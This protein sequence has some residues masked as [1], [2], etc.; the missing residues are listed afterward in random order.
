MA[1][2]R[3][4]YTPERPAL[5]WGRHLLPRRLRARIL[6]VALVALLPVGLLV[7]GRALARLVTIGETAR[8]DNQVAAQGGAR[9][10]A[11]YVEE[12]RQQ[13]V[14]LGA[15]IG[16]RQ[17]NWGW[18]NR[19]LATSATQNPAL[20]N[21]SW[22]SSQGLVL[23]SSAPAALGAVI[24]E[25]ASIR[26][27]RA[28][29]SWVISDLLP[30]GPISRSVSIVLASA[31]RTSGGDLLGILV[32]EVNPDG[33]REVLE[34]A[35][36]PAGSVAVLFDR[37]GTLVAGSDARQRTWEERAAWRPSDPVLRRALA[38][39]REAH[40]V[41]TPVTLATPHYAVYAPTA[42]T[43]YLVG[44]VQP[45]ATARASVW[46]SALRDV[47][48]LALVTGLVG[49]IAYYLSGTIVDPVRRLRANLARVERQVTGVPLS[50]EAPAE[51]R[52]LQAALTA[53]TATLLQRIAASEGDRD[54][55][56]TILELLPVGV[57]F[58]NA[59]GE[60][61]LANPSA[62]ELFGEDALGMAS[63][64]RGRYS[65]HRPDGSPLPLAEVPLVAALHEGQ[66][67]RN[68]EVIIRYESGA[69][70]LALV[71]ATPVPDPQGATMGVVE[72]VVEVV[73]DAVALQ[74]ISASTNLEGQLADVRA[75]LQALLEIVPVGVFLLDAGGGL[76][77][78]NP[79]GMRLWG[80][81]LPTLKT[82]SDF[83]FLHGWWTRSGDP[84]RPDDWPPVRALMTN[85]PVRH[86]AIT[87]NRFDG[88]R[89]S[90]LTSAAPVHTAH[91][92][93]SGAVWV[94]QDA[95]GGK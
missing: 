31:T 46:R 3:S 63:T 14:I 34:H 11:R 49:L 57:R 42:G 89:G 48:L 39:G 20:R 58:V 65:L 13:A 55:L 1:G 6:L 68:V 30:A 70:L 25:D 87:L 4:R 73:S 29:R 84:L 71:S 81:M 51:L 77:S 40:G 59:S 78:A 50:D 37:R 24:G 85:E 61:L 43:G 92:A 52:D 15:A 10:V 21:V 86:A 16:T 67:S 75:H 12:I 32:A 72:V 8:R 2:A 45:R 9:A 26:S 82:S 76:L 79:E 60:V 88:L 93:V 90:V 91:G 17:P 62:R 18:T 94:I 19:L 66:A 95:G 7:V 23:A 41:V 80:G 38:T 83:R 56:Q 47:L 35:R 33:L 74:E 5:G 69:G 22:I 64:P 36:R 28:G 44:L 54:R 27:L 53:I